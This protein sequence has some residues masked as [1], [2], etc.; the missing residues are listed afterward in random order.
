M[1]SNPVSS[2]I[3]LLFL[4]RTS[5]MMTHH[6]R[7]TYHCTQSGCH[8]TYSDKNSLKHHCASRH[9]VH[10]TSPS[11]TSL[12]YNYDLPASLWEPTVNRAASDSRGLFISQPKP[13]STPVLKDPS[14]SGKLKLGLGCYAEDTHPAQVKRSTP[15]ESWTLATASES[16]K[17]KESTKMLNS[18]QW[19]LGIDAFEENPVVSQIPFDVH[20]LETNLDFR[21]SYPEERKEMLSFQPKREAT[22]SSVGFPTRPP[23]SVGHKKHCPILL[24]HSLKDP[25]PLN[26]LKRRHSFSSSTPPV[27]LV[28]E[29][30]SDFDC[31]LP[32]PAL[33]SPPLHAPLPNSRKR[34]SCSK[35]TLSNVPTPPLP[36]PQPGCHKRSRSRSSYLVSPS[37]VALASFSTYLGNPFLQKVHNIP[38]FPIFHPCLKR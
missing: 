18:T 7:K 12:A 32:D 21:E 24:K 3:I 23:G 10:F 5:H 22:T 19:T 9:G 28:P 31:N 26:K 34:K 13:V 8:K 11:S 37:Q 25:K 16:Y 38:L 20:S 27:L 1:C 15:Q 6:K 29:P 35:D 30:K 4:R 2:V 33:P 36:V 17:I 14:Y